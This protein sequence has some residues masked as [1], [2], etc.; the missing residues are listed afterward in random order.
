MRRRRRRRRK[1]TRSGGAQNKKK[2]KERIAFALLTSVNSSREI[3]MFHSI[4]R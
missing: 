2:K 3:V 4:L 1:K